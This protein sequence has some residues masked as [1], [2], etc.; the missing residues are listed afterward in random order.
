LRNK[1]K[2][3]ATYR[4]WYVKNREKKLAQR[5]LYG[6][7]HPDRCK[8][9]SRAS[10]YKNRDKRL[11]YY[12]L[13]YPFRKVSIRNAD[14]QKRYGIGIKEYNLLFKRQGGI[15]A[16]CGGSPGK[17]NLAVDHDHGD[18]KIRGLLCARCNRLLGCSLDKQ[19]VLR[20]AIRYLAKKRS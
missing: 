5:R 3:K 10:Y 2:E 7:N 20:A 1:E 8:A 6:K 15:C 17:R 16:I 14:L 18:G 13:R 12:K 19:S 11:A 4:R 9:S